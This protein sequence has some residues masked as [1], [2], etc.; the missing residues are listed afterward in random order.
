M[1]IYLIGMM[2]SGKST[3]GKILAKKMAIP[4]IDLDHYIEVKNNKS[5]SN[6]FKENGEAHF[7]ELESDALSQ[8]EESTVLVACGGGIVQNKI[9]REKLLSTGKV[10]FLHTSIPEIA[11][12]LKDS[13]DRPLLKEKE[14]IQELTKIWNGRKDYYQETAHILVNTDRQ[15]PNEISED[16]FK[17]VHS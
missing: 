12:R 17:Q 7:R 4:F 11:K 16:I 3:V 14:R 10:V 6:I 2:G 15:S 13:I 5:I 8:I 1:N 9:N